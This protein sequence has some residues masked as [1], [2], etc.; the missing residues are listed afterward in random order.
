[1]FLDEWF[2]ENSLLDI[3]QKRAIMNAN[4]QS[5]LSTDGFSAV[6]HISCSKGGF[7]MN[8]ATISPIMNRFQYFIKAVFTPDFVPERISFLLTIERQF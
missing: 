8:T 6:F 5:N 2:H 7:I 3:S 1:L 4:L